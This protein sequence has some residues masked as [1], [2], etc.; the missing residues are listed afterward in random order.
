[1]ASPDN[2]RYTQDHMWVLVEGNSATVGITDHAQKQL[3]DIVYV[4]LPEIGIK[5]QS[6]DEI[7]NVESVKA[8]SD[9]FTP[10]SG[11]IIG[12]NEDL[13][14]EPD[15]LNE[16]PYGE[17]WIFKVKMSAPDEVKKLMTAKA[18]DDYVSNG[19]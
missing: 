7:G 18:Y 16:D 4:E 2:L 12:I 13:R 9:I 14:D 8:V 15:I 11:E 3:G 6:Q 17:A 1:M 10:L 5:R 19:N